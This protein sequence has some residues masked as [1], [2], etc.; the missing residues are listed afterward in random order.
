MEVNY[1][2]I[3]DDP[4]CFAVSLKE[5]LKYGLS[6]LSR[7]REN[8]EVIKYEGFL[9][10]P[11]KYTR[12]IENTGDKGRIKEKRRLKAGFYKGHEK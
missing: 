5:A 4:L 1:E 3:S 12:E 7:L 2:K 11:G 6:P 8:P 10:Y 9:Q